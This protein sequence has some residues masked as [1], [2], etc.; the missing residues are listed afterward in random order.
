M[1]NPE[2]LATFMAFVNMTEYEKRLTRICIC[3][4][5]TNLRIPK[6]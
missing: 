1:D 3:V 5:N 6:G 4:I 2:K